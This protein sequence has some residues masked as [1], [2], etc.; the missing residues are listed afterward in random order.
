MAPPRRSPLERTA[1]RLLTGPVGH[2]AG[3]FLDWAQALAGVVR[4]RTRRRLRVTRS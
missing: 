1:A 4:R 3:G 2:F